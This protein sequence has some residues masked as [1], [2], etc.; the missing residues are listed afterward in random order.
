MY[1]RIVDF[2][3]VDHTVGVCLICCIFDSFFVLFAE[4]VFVLVV[5]SLILF[6]FFWL[7]PILSRFCPCL[8]IDGFGAHDEIQLF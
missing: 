2:Q 6:L 7:I 4:V 8:F 3:Y 1:V 5:V